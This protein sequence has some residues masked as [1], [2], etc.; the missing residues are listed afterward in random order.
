MASAFHLLR[1]IVRTSSTGVLGRA[2]FVPD[3]YVGTSTFSLLDTTWHP[4][5]PLT[6]KDNTS[7]VFLIRTEVRR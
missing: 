2:S 4:S 6:L 1:A 5:L 7:I 3:Y